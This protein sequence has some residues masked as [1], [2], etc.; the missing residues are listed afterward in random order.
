[1]KTASD[2]WFADLNEDGNE[3]LMIGRLP[4]QTPA[5]ATNVV[6][7][8]TSRGTPSGTW[9][10]KAVL[11]ADVSDGWNFESSVAALAGLL[12]PALQSSSTVINIGSTPSA[13]DAIQSAINSGA[14]FVDYVGHGSIS[15]WDH[16][17]LTAWDT[18]A[19][20]NGNKLPFIAGMTC[21]NNYFHDVFSP[22]LGEALMN[23]PNGGA[24][25]VWSSSSLTEP[26]PQVIMNQ[27]LLRHIFGAN[28]TI[29]QAILRAKQATRDE[30]V[31]RSWNL[32]GDPT[33]KLKP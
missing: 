2:G 6:G 7:K 32:L 18:D 23:A 11:I 3:D 5:Q 29:G 15:L 16:N 33:M 31:R 27:E 9:S 8:L 30:D 21:L 26:G 22:S 1:M 24:I 28:T 10:Q 19:L 20:T 17:T 4:V 13:R 14:L 25:A 12:P